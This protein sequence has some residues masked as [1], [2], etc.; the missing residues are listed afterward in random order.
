VLDD[1]LATTSPAS[2]SAE[3]WR[4]LLRQ[5]RPRDASGPAGER[6]EHALASQCSGT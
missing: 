6:V 2:Y 1:F 4:A 5:G 3:Q